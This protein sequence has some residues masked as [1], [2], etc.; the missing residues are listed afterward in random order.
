MNLKRKQIALSNYPYFKHSLDFTLDSLERLGGNAIELYCCD[1]H[2]CIDDVGLPEAMAMKKK[3]RAHGLSPICLTPEQVKYPINIASRNP[4][5]RKRS[6]GTY[7]KVI[8]FASEL[9]SP[10]VQFHAGFALLDE[11]YDDTWKRSV[12]SL[13]YLSNIA[14]GYGVTITMESAHRLCTILNSSAHVAKMVKA[15]GSPSLTGMIDTLCLEYCHEDVNT[16]IQ[17]LGAD[18]IRHIHFSDCNVNSPDGH[19]IPGE[20]SMDLDAIIQALDAIHYP[21]YITLEI[22]SPYEYRPEEAMGK[23]KD[24]LFDRIPD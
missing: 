17:N 22:M 11:D 9:E 23:T 4:T 10:T 19:V 20:G 7:V 5:A 18:K 24:W 15:I 16:A 12:D 13:E 2:F 14:E 3:L 1:P 8:Q 21:N 6:V